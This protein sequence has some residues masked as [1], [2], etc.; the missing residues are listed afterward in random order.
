M[1]HWRLRMKT[2]KGPSTSLRN[3]FC[4]QASTCTRGSLYSHFALQHR[5]RVDQVVIQV[6]WTNIVIHAHS[7]LSWFWIKYSSQ[8]HVARIIECKHSNQIRKRL[9]FLRWLCSWTNVLR[10]LMNQVESYVFFLSSYR[11]PR[12]QSWICLNHHPR[13]FFLS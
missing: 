13:C 8:T 6:A 1:G 11:F 12:T 5:A 4:W 7:L 3:K 9:S 2:K 10:F